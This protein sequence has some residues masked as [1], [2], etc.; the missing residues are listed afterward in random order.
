L[1]LKAEIIRQEEFRKFLVFFLYL[2]HP[3][4]RPR[5]SHEAVSRW[6]PDSFPRLGSAEGAAPPQEY[7]R[8]PVLAAD[9]GR[10][11]FELPATTP[12]AVRRPASR[13]PLLS[14]DAPERRPDGDGSGS[15]SHPAERSVRASSSRARGPTGSLP[16]GRCSRTHRGRQRPGRVLVNHYRI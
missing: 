10:T 9:L 15:A 3:R 2:P 6:E 7:R 14:L 11:R 1:I 5:P 16:A 4:L 8:A 13:R 12:V